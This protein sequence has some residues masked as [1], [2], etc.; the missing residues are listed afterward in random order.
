MGLVP[1]DPPVAL[2]INMLHP[3][4]SPSSALRVDKAAGRAA[5]VLA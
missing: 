3:R 5:T 4:R 1:D 2:S